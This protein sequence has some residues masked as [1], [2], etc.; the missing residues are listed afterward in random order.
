M[1]NF[2]KITAEQ[3]SVDPY[4]FYNRNAMDKFQISWK[5]PHDSMLAE[6]NRCC[7]MYILL[8]NNHIKNY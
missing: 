7:P 3:P 6:D 5:F 2:N 4:W 8:L 1:F